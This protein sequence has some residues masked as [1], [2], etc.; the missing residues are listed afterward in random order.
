MTPEGEG[1]RSEYYSNKY[2]YN[3]KSVRPHEPSRSGQQ[4]YPSTNQQTAQPNYGQ[5]PP[6]Y[7]P[8]GPYSRAFQEKIYVKIF[9]LGIIFFLVGYLITAVTGYMDAPDRDDFDDDEDYKDELDWYNLIK[10]SLGTTGNIL[11]HIG[12]ILIVVASPF[13]RSL[14]AS[15]LGIVGRILISFFLLL[16]SHHLR[17]FPLK[18]INVFSCY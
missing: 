5:Y 13:H 16:L 2:E 3:P 6:P 17:L 10:R 11:E 7:R 8:P 14:V 18:K 4:H 12:L 1:K 15:Y 9:I